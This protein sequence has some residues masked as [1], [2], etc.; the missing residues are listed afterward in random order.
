MV[1]LTK[2]MNVV[3]QMSWEEFKTLVIEK[4]CPYNE[5]EKIEAEFWKLEMVGAAH[6]EYMN[7][8]NELSRLVPHLVTPESKRIGHYI[9]GLA[10]LIRGMVKSAMPTTF[11][12]SV[13]LAGSLTDEMVW[14]GS[15]ANPSAGN[16]RQWTGNTTRR[17]EGN[18]N[19]RNNRGA[20]KSYAVVAKEEGKY[21]SG[22]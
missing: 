17:F 5:V 19:K 20:I 16:K 18:P 15:L 4:Y 9:W 2:G 7:R 6:Q 11:H 10:P 12:S 22:N 14:N 3:K 21:L 13:V 8:F 1:V